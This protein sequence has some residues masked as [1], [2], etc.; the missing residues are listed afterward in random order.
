M[1][2]ENNKVVSF[3]FTLTTESGEVLEKSDGNPLTYI[4]GT[5]S[6]IPGL[7][8]EL[9]GKSAG[10]AFKVTVKPENAYGT[11]NEQ[12]VI[13]VP[14]EHFK[15][16]PNLAIGMQLQLQGEQGIQLVTVKDIKDETVSIDG[17]HP[18]ADM[19]LNFDVKVTD[20]REAT[21]EELEHGHVH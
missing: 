7:E 18:L 12:L 5:S 10:D 21:D 13:D 15:E 2:I 1:I 11:R 16:I 14:I 17:N 6:L 8:N 20:I 4:H 19:T 3:D 9:T